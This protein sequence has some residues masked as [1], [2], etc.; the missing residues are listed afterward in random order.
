[1][2][3]IIL[4]ITSKYDPTGVNHAERGLSG[5]GKFA[6]GAG[7]AIAAGLAVGAT[8]LVRFGGDA[9]KA[10]AD[11]EAVSRSF[12]QIAKN[13]GFFGTEEKQIRAASDALI[14]HAEKMS[15]LTG[16]DDEAFISLE[17]YFMSVPEL[18]GIGE[19]GLQGLA[20]VTADIAAATG[21]DLESVGNALAKAM[22]NPETAIS[23]L[24]R[25]GVFLSDSQVA[26]YDSLVATG[27]AAEAQGYLIE[28]LGDK[29]AGAAEAAANPFEQLRAIVENF[30]EDVGAE[31]LPVFQE[32]IPI[33]AEALSTLA[34]DPA[35]K[36]MLLDMAQTFK[37]MI[38]TL[39]ELMPQLMELGTELFPTLVDVLVEITPVLIKLLPLVADLLNL[40]FLLLE[41]LLQEIGL[42]ASLTDSFIEMV[43]TGGDL[44]D[45][46]MGAVNEFYKIN[47]M[48][49]T[50]ID[51]VWNLINAFSRLF[52]FNFAGG[53]RGAFADMQGQIARAKGATSGLSG[54]QY[55][56]KALG[57]QIGGDGWSWVGENGP[58]LAKFPVGTHITPAHKTGDVMA[59]GGGSTYNINISTLK[60]DATIGEV[61]V[62]SIKKY[63]RTSGAVFASA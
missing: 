42:V 59:G 62:N 60:A 28:Q 14:K 61:I 56:G 20:Q 30:K 7:I 54:S 22:A 25:A 52:G 41:P 55:A 21:K 13:S 47:G 19:K 3:D 39:I 26:V 38:P 15:E 10:A 17:R 48:L 16:I 51:M 6:A 2:R 40:T 27:Q 9:I 57:G 18:A 1:M 46:A 45:W 29:Y 43:K 33:I 63:E 53:W 32:I 11:A 8:A 12:E 5:L 49:S 31:L 23:K 35:F 34:S 44:N 50:S 4:P 37:E 58:E 24:Q 36:Q